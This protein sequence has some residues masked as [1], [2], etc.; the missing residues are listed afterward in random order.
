M[1]TGMATPS[2]AAAAQ[3]RPPASVVGRLASSD[4]VEG[5]GFTPGTILA[6]RYRIIGLIGR[7]GMGEVY[8][9]DD[10]KLGQ[11]VALKFLPRALAGDRQRLDRFFTEVSTARQV[12]HPNVSGFFLF[13][14]LI[15]LVLTVRF[16]FLAGAAFMVVHMILFAF[17]LTADPKAW[18]AGSGFLALGVTAALLL[19]GAW[20]AA[21]R[22]AP[23]AV[24]TA[25]AA[26]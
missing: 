1:P 15:F 2:V 22:A 4:A 17:P 6:E 7:G 5:G 26:T 24:S 13:L 23:A 19:W 25:P 20:A 14:Q 9:A 3:R 16:G 12:S 18:Y 8:R 11:P 21:G 10:L